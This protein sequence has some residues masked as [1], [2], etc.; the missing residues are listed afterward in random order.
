MMLGKVLDRLRESSTWAGLAALSALLS[1]FGVKI[2]AVVFTLGPELMD[3][4]TELLAGF[5]IIAGGA[6]VAMPERKEPPK[7]PDEPF[8]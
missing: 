5:G 4:L 1:I 6:A 2:P 3:L 7:N 8:A